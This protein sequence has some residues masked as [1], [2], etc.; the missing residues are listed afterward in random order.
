MQRKRIINDIW[1][2]LVLGVMSVIAL[3]PFYMMF[4]M[5]TY[6]SEDLF[7]GLPLLVSDYFMENL[8]TTLDNGL[9]A[10]YLNSILVSAASVIACLFTSIT[11]GYALAKFT[12][13]GQ[14]AI[15]ILVLIGMMLPTQIS[16]IGL[17]LIH[18]S[19]PTRP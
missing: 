1:V 9:L 18:I 16:I 11:I 17:S 19:E 15:L 14:K 8:K 4:V 2:Y 3:F 12:F 13:R 5:G 10:T 7:H 6:Y